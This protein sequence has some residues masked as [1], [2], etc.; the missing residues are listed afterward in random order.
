M[1]KIE[2]QA[3]ILQMIRERD[4]VENEE[5]V[6]AFMVTSATIRRDL[7][8]LSEQGLIRLDHGGSSTTGLIDNFVEPQYETKIY[9][10]HEAKRAIGMAAADM[11]QEDEV[12]ILDSGTTNAQIAHS[13]RALR[14][15]HLTVVTCDLIVAK[16]L[17]PDPMI[18]VILLGGSLR[19]SFYSTY[20]PYAEAVLKNMRANK[21]FLG[22]DAASRDFGITN[23]V[24]EEVP[25]K[26]LA[27]QNS[28]QIIMVADASKLGKNALHRVC[29][30]ETID[31]VITDQCI[32]QEDLDFLKTQ[33][34]QTRVV[35]PPTPKCGERD[36]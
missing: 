17:C 33:N 11:V 15:K 1:I 22:I 3:K 6:R 21:F 34:I 12:I 23:I 14:P 13:L 8:E 36:S 16:E 28:D 24:L 20:G 4:F 35:S 9:L 5:L 29:D 32:C 30:W 2:R 27:I 31:M 26:Q 10:N 18:D 7:K 19:R 25:I